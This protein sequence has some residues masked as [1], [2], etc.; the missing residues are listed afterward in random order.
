MPNAAQATWLMSAPAT[1]QMRSVRTSSLAGGQSWTVAW[2]RLHSIQVSRSLSMT[3]C[4]SLS[5]S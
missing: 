5:A 2:R 3:A 4:T 1:R